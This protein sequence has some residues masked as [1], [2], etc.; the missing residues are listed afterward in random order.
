MI[1]GQHYYIADIN[2]ER[3]KE[4]LGRPGNTR[5]SK[6]NEIVITLLKKI[7]FFADLKLAS[8]DWVE[9]A[10]A[11]GIVK[12]KIGDVIFEYDQPGDKFI[13]LL[14]GHLDVYVPNAAIENFQ[15][16]YELYQN[17][18]R[19]KEILQQINEAG[20]PRINIDELSEMESPR[21]SG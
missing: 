5:T 15:E 4:V 10:N 19:E 11:L 13:V 12:P 21:V 20:S 8:Y 18:L 7:K 14:D 1:D 16:E 17:V 9:L 3:L 2:L 6:T